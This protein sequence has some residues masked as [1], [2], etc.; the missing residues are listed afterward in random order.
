M[1]IHLELE[2]CKLSYSVEIL[3]VTFVEEK[4]TEDFGT[5]VPHFFLT[6]I[7]VWSQSLNGYSSHGPAYLQN[8]CGTSNP[9]HTHKTA[10]GKHHVGLYLYICLFV[11]ASFQSKDSL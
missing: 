4:V 8:S 10:G 2:I 1:W 9:S 6:I 3:M 5:E 7:P 11:L